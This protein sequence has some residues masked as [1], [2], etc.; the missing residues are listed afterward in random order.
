MKNDDKSVERNRICVDLIG[1]QIGCIIIAGETDS[2]PITGILLPMK[3][4]PI[5]LPS[6]V[7]NSYDTSRI[8]KF[9]QNKHFQVIP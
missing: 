2:M 7:A 5:P 3:V 9:Y 4:G 6:L 8:L 1:K